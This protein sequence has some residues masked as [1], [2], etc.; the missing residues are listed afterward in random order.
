MKVGRDPARDPAR[1]QAARDAIAS[2]V[3]LFVDANGAYSRKQAFAFA[4]RFAEFDVRWFE[5]PVRSDDLDGLR[6]LR[7]RAPAEQ[8]ITRANTAATCHISAACSMQERSTSC[9][10]TRRAAVELPV[11]ARAALCEAHGLPLSGHCC[12]ALHTHAL[13]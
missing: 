10:L 5:E 2:D 4:D 6:L 11:F 3:E 9:R 12:P 13:C 8:Q 7:D 1:V